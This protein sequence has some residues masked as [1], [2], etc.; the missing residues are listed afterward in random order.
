MDKLAQVLCLLEKIP[1][2]MLDNSLMN[3][4]ELESIILKLGGLLVDGNGRFLYE[5][6]CDKY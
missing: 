3:K 4:K 6:N 2:A 5:Y 1:S